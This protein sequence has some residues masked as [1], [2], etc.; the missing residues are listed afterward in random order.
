MQNMS[1][2]PVFSAVD[3]VIP[4]GCEAAW[5]ELFLTSYL[6]SSLSSDSGRSDP[7]LRKGRCEPYH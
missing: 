6:L 7:G 4:G 5:S 3:M 1:T 2:P